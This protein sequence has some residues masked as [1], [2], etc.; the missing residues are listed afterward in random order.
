MG[1]RRIP[2]LDGVRG[3][4]IL[5]VLLW[6]YVANPI[7][8]ADGT[9]AWYI[10]AA[11]GLTWSGVDLFFVL[12]G[13]L[14]AGILVDNRSAS[15]FYRVFYI[16]RVCRIFPVYFLLLGAFAGL[17][18]TPLGRSPD[19]D[20]LFRE[21]LPLWSYASFTQNIIMSLR[22]DFGA[23]WL[24]ITWSL[25]VEEQFYLVIPTLVLLLSRR[26][27][28]AAFVAGI[29]MAPI[30]RAVEPGFAAYVGTPWR[31]D[32][33][34]GGAVL[35][36]LVRR[37]GFTA[38]AERARPYLY[39]L[40]GVFLVGAAY[41]T[42]RPSALG[43]MQYFFLAT[44]YTLLVLIAYTERDGGWIGRILGSRV[45]VWFGSLSYGI[46]MFHQASN[47]LFH[48]AVH[49]GAPRLESLQDVL[50]MVAAFATT[51][52]AAVASFRYFELPILRWGHGF[53]YHGP[54]GRKVPVPAP[55]PHV[56]VSSRST[57]G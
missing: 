35:A 10:K 1:S 9:W 3:V 47:G 32:A 17:T 44:M 26:Y 27:L 6:H 50:L 45:L 14:I 5:L 30:L 22:G 52:L 29:A 19:F 11:L 34:L 12:S 56:S 7:T 2:Q 16:R 31:A 43:P 38:S 23:N 4:A 57:I 15:N 51:L 54:D 24:G 41:L 20:W 13:F 37:D 40:L 18:L 25:A 48:G 39:L 46:Y 55:T 42:L 21:P 28:A 53:R 8:A 49:G 33:L 36:L